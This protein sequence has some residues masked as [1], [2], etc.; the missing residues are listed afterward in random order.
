[1]LPLAGTDI[2]TNRRTYEEI[3]AASGYTD[4]DAMNS[5]M[6]ILESELKLITTTESYDRSR[7][8]SNSSE[9]EPATYQLSHDFLV[10]SIRDWL[11]ALSKRAHGEDESNRRSRNKLNT[12]T[13]SPAAV[14]AQ[15]LGVCRHSC[16]FEG[17]VCVRSKG[18]CWE[19]AIAC[20]GSRL[21][22]QVLPSPWAS[23]SR[24][25]P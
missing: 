3:R 6:T 19:R 2:K 5:L 10:P 13:T 15:F 11:S 17:S 9:S 21:L 1:M 24:K 16:W 8:D 20:P 18:K 4:R 14:P 22:W 23:G 25:R 7:S 12:V